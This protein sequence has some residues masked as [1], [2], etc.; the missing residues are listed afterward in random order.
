MERHNQWRGGRRIMTTGYA[1]VRM[2]DHP[3]ACRGYV[4]EHVV[5][6]ERA[7]GRELRAPAEVHHFD[8]NRANNAP[9]NLVVCQDHAYH[10]LLHRR[11]EA[12]AM[13]GDPNAHKCEICHGFG[14]QADLTV[15]HRPNGHF[16]AYHRNCARVRSN[17]DHARRRATERAA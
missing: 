13:T 9:E 5:V 8:E 3:R 17:A 2:P 6:V 10:M 15:R 7:M 12:L 4:L 16:R 14:D 1:Q 11:A